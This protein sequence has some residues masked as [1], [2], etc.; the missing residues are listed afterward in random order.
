MYIDDPVRIAK[1]VD[2]DLLSF[3]LEDDEGH[4]IHHVKIETPWIVSD[5]SLVNAIY[6]GERESGAKYLISSS[7][8]NEEIIANMTGIVDDVIANNKISLTQ[9]VLN[10]DSADLTQII[11]LDI[12]GWMP[13]FVQKI[14]TNRMIYTVQYQVKFIMEGTVKGQTYFHDP[15]WFN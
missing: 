15:T 5:R 11:S 13:T 6:V 14:F 12:G 3:R 7:R 10:E 8:G 4:P 1:E 9:L 2:P